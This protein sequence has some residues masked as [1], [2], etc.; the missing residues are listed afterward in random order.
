MADNTDPDTALIE[1]YQGFFREDLLKNKVA[2]ITGGAT[3]IGFTIAEVFMRHQC[4]TVI[5]SRKI[6]KLKK[7]AK[8]LEDATGRR[9]L[10]VV[11]DVRKPQEVVHMV[12]QALSHFG[13]IDILVNNAAGNFLAPAN[14]LSFNAFKTVVDIDTLGTFNA[15]K[16][17]YDKYMKDHG[18]VILNI[19]ATLQY[20]GTIFQTHAASAKAAI[21]AM[22]RSLAV[23]WGGQGIRINCLAPGPIENTEGIRKLAGLALTDTKGRY[24]PLGRMGTREEIGECALF[25]ASGAS[26]FITGTVIVVDGGSWM[27]SENSMVQAEQVLE[28]MSKSR[29]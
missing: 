17:V 5:A 12:E 3:G 23:E 29:L 27:T 25:L 13:K 21:D 14:S 19:S 7:A 18:G 4:D 8:I 6:D 22:T 1:N 10:T 24:I 11:M 2:I 16:A 15:T 28:Q 26:S 9:C 20:K